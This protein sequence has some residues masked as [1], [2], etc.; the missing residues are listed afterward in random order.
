MK[1]TLAIWSYKFRPWF[2]SPWPMDKP[3]CNPNSSLWLSCLSRSPPPRETHQTPTASS[4]GAGFSLCAGTVKSYRPIVSTP[5]TTLSVQTPGVKWYWNWCTGGQQHL[6][7]PIPKN[8]LL[9][10]TSTGAKPETSGQSNP[11]KPVCLQLSNNTYECA[12]ALWQL[13]ETSQALLSPVPLT[14]PLPYRCPS[15]PERSACF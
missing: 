5:N 11:R 3:A 4:E 10:S 12:A 9:T 8:K 15:Q 13:M 1:T 2:A 14:W 6:G 7:P